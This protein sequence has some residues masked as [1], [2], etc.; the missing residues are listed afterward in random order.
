MQ[1]IFH[2]HLGPSSH[3]SVFFWNL[4]ELRWRERAAREAGHAHGPLK[5]EQFVH[6]YPHHCLARALRRQMHLPRAVLYAIHVASELLAV[7]YRSH[8][9]P[10]AERVQIVAIEQ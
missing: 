1:S 5:E 8:V 6:P 10:C 7:V 2:K 9:I 3:E 4:Q